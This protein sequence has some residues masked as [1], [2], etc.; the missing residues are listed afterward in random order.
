MH[1]TFD[2]P[3]WW[4]A[5]TLAER[6]LLLA[7]EGAAAAPPPP[8]RMERAAR[9]AERWRREA[10][11]VEDTLFAERLALDGLT[12]ASFLRI[13]AEPAAGLR[14]RA[15]GPPPWLQTLAR[16]F[17]QPS[18]P[19]P[20]RDLGVL[21]LLRPLIADASSRVLLELR[22]LAEG[23]P[24]L[25]D[26]EAVS[27][28]LLTTLLRRLRWACERTLA[29]ELQ[30]GRIEGKLAGETSEERFRSFVGI[31]AR[32]AAALEILQR[33]PVLARD[34][35]RHAGQW[36][37]TSLEMLQRLAVDRSE[38]VHRL[39]ARG[40]PG[41]LIAAE[42]GLSDRHAGGRSVAILAFA[43][44]L[45]I[46]YKP[47]PLAVDLRFQ[48]LV[49]W[50]DD[51]G[52]EPPLRRLTVLDRG[53]YGWVEHVAARPCES[54]AEVARFH[55]RQGAWVALLYVLEAN[56]FHHENLIA[57]GEHPVPI[58][59]ETLFQPARSQPSA[60]GPGYLPTAQTVLN[61]G[62]LP[63]RFWDTAAEEG[64]LDLSGMGAAGGQ[65][66]EVRRIAGEGT[67]EMRWA[68][69]EMSLEAG[70]NLPTL[71]GEPVA[72]WEHGG[73]VLKG[74]RSMYQL[75]RRHREELLSPQ[76]P[77]A[78]FAGL[79]VRTL[80]RGTGVYAH[81]LH[82][83][84]HPDYL[85]SA[86]DR[87]RLY[88]RLWLDAVG[89]PPFRRAVRREREDLIAGDVPLWGAPAAGT[90]LLHTGG[91]RIAGFFATS[92]MELVQE[93]LRAMG[94]DDLE[95]QSWLV[96]ASIE[97][98][99]ALDERWAW[100]ATRL[101]DAGP[102][103]PERFLAAARRIGDRLARLAVEQGGIVTW[104]HLDLRPGGWFLEPMPVDLYNGLCGLA[105]FLAHL[106]RLTGEERYEQL[107]RL[108]LSTARRRHEAAPEA[109]PGAF[110]G[111]G[112]VV[113]ALTHL[114][115]L[116]QEPELLDEAVALA[117]TT[118]GI[119]SDEAFDVIAGSAGAAAALLALH[120]HRPTAAVLAAAVR[121]GERLLA[122]AV[123]G[124]RGTA[125]PPLGGSG[126]VPITG[127]SHGTA[128]IAWALARLAQAS[129]DERFRDAARGALRYERS[130]FDPDGDNWPDLRESHRSESG[131]DFLY[132]W[133]HGAPGIGLGR[134][135]TLPCMEDP[136]MLAEIRAAARATL[137]EGFGGSQCLCHGDLGNLELVREAGR[138]LGDTTLT[139]E[140]DRLAAR[141]LARIESGGLRC[142]T[143]AR[144]E[145][146]GLMVG[147][148]GI[149]YGLLRAAWPER[150]PSVLLLETPGS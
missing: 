13:L 21:E 44:G 80:L 46:V 40:D 3:E 27:A 98:T 90:D 147:L 106:G 116:W 138:L 89:Y 63:R 137:A 36:V 26:A 68:R 146:L 78:P 101:P 140:A 23:A 132:A 58:D 105:L 62:L 34:A 121:C 56:D 88:D 70:P 14:R 85:R 16:T 107:A 6:A 53:G 50:L 45:R 149:G 113:Y 108:A 133:C 57:E 97:A 35:C 136:E 127:F 141:V 39:A 144:T 120:R 139:A 73:A 91:D 74:F 32:P 25:L 72:L 1:E 22:R 79:P 95:R 118:P 82:V 64:G 51:H 114:G 29:L 148:A 111:W 142:G 104:F 54:P 30:I 128:G 135:G 66:L 129:G 15:D 24:G 94:D 4:D 123:V 43:S 28:P 41:P 2:A 103:G 102:A 76:G 65:T 92:G 71:R 18:P 122:G 5:L 84:H 112:G 119:E 87:D 11:L 126:R 115:V 86:L 37:E 48:E 145:S 55:E 8:E 52:A 100:P 134:I 38:I 150:V 31:L 9:Q 110:N 12:S 125:W 75:L 20:V 59:L 49:G 60:G 99:R 42:T 69:Q 61:S 7:A 124:E 47:K 81:L 109:L 117:A 130:W 83:A 77:L 93:R 96:E 10:D 17:S 67:D 131:P 33:Y 19:L 143:S